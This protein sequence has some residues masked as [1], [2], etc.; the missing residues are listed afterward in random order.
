M[1]DVTL[2]VG[3]MCLSIGTCLGFL[4]AAML[5]MSSKEDDNDLP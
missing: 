1:T 5:C 4:L 2:I 3:I